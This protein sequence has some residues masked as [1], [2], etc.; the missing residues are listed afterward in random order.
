M[1]ARSSRQTGFTLIE[2]MIVVTIIGILA[3]IAFPAYT[4]YTTRTH[5]AAARACVSEAAQFMERY[6]TT[7]LTYVGAAPALGCQTEGGL[8]TWYT[9]TADTLAQNTYR[10]VATPIG[11]QATRDK[12][13]GTLTVDQ[14]GDR[15]ESGTGD[16]TECWSR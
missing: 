13:C 4:S 10:L 5:R 1:N 6:Y 15:T 9:I 3:A 8:N 11:A 12:T 14:A 2:L 7:G 16:V